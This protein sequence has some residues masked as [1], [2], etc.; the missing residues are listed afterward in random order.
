MATVGD[1]R[2]KGATALKQAPA[3][4]GNKNAGALNQFYRVTGTNRTLNQP[5]VF[6]WNFVAPTNTVSPTSGPPVAGA[7]NY[8]SLNQTQQTP[9]LFNNRGIIGRAQINAGK[10][11]EVRATPVDP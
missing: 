11:I 2:A 5:V 4:A 1:D 3:A 10:E 8:Q 6:T 7:L 9:G